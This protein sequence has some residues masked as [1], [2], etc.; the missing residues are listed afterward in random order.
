MDVYTFHP[1]N[2]ESEDFCFLFIASHLIVADDGLELMGGSLHPGAEY[3]NEDDSRH[4]ASQRV[5]PT[6]SVESSTAQAGMDGNDPSHNEFSQRMAGRQYSETSTGAGSLYVSPV[7]KRVEAGPLDLEITGGR[8]PKE[9]L[10]LVL[11]NELNI[12]PWGTNGP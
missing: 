11:G 12:G 3:T 9:Q 8:A 2:P 7:P 5:V 4:P 10:S 1:T 6:I